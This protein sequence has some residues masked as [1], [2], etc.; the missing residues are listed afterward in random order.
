MHEFQCPY[1]L[2]WII[3]RICML[4]FDNGYWVT[5]VTRWFA[6]SCTISARISNG[7]ME[8]QNNSMLVLI[9][10]FIS[11]IDLMTNSYSN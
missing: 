8:L 2:E 10:I 11:M 9:S 7:V 1:L 3:L 5:T 6:V 4:L